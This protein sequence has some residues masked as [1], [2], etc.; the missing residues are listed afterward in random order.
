MRDGKGILVVI[1]AWNEEG[2]VDYVVKEV[3]AAVPRADVVVVDDGS[4][5]RTG[6]SA[7]AAGARVLTA[8]FNLGVGGAM[9]TGFRFAA[10]RG[11]D[12][13]VQVDADG[14]HDPGEIETL[15]AALGGEDR[16]EVV[17]GAR[18]A[19][20]G[21][22]TVR[23]PRRWAMRMLA[24]YLSHV[25]G[26]KLTDVTSGFR[27]HN[28]AAVELFAATYPAEYLLDTVESLVIA[29]RRGGRV[30]QVPVGMRPRRAGSPSQSVP[31]SVVY[32]ARALLVLLLAIIRRW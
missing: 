4:T 14:Q 28:R 30:S 10:E 9:R 7:R 25:A 13:V 5:D 12:V 27:A 6:D 21:E 18:F 26:T 17:V 8:P 23:G 15:V 32:L 20:K 22:V 29:V 2:S 16:P 24:S 31:K 19:G 11:Y 3:A 1:P